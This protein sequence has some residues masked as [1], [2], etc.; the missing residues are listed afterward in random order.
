MNWLIWGKQSTVIG[1]SLMKNGLVVNV[2]VEGACGIF[3]SSMGCRGME[4]SVSGCGWGRIAAISGNLCSS[5]NIPWQI[6]L[7]CVPLCVQPLESL[8]IPVTRMLPGCNKWVMRTVNAFGFLNSS[9]FIESE[10]MHITEGGIWPFG[11]ERAP[12]SHFP[13]VSP[14]PCKI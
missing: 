8:Q 9:A 7:H 6:P 11:W 14:Q 13:T 1:R 2:R 12:H 10:K 3:P 4:C 5:A